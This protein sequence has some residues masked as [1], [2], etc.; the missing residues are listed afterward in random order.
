MTKGSKLNIKSTR[1]AEAL[2]RSGIKAK[3]QKATPSSAK[4]AKSKSATL[5][6]EAAELGASEEL[7]TPEVQPRVKARSHSAFEEAHQETLQEEPESVVAEEEVIFV[8]EA[9]VEE[10]PPPVEEIVQIVAEEAPQAAP[11]QVEE[12]APEVK[13]EVIPPPAPTPTPAPAPVAEKAPPSA[14]KPAAP[15]KD[16]PR[17]GAQPFVLMK[18]FTQRREEEAA[19]RQEMQKPTRAPSA[20]LL[21]PTGRHIRDLA[22]KEVER[23]PRPAEAAAERHPPRERAEREAPA[24]AREAGADG[25]ARNPNKVLE[26]GPVAEKGRAKNKLK[27]FEDLKPSKKA[28]KGVGPKEARPGQESDEGSWSRRRAPKVKRVINEELTVR[29]KELSVRLPITIKDLA[30]Q[31]KLK[32][33]QLIQKLFLQGVVVTL[34][35]ALEDPTTVQLLGHEFEVNINIDTSE[36]ARLRITD[37]T[38]KEEIA[39]AAEDNVTIRPPVA[40]FMGHVDHGKTSLIDAIR[41]SN[42]AHGEAGAITQHIGAFRCTTPAGDLAIL[43][44]PGHEAFSAMRARGAE[45]TDIVVLVVAGDEGIR[46]QTEEAIQHAKAAG[47]TIIVACNKCDK[48]NFDVEKVYRQLA[49]M[50]L[51]PEAWGG[52]TITVNTSAITGEGIETL[53]EMIALQSEVLELKANPSARARGTVLESAMHKGMGTVATLLVQNGTLRAGDSLVFSQHWGRVKTLTNEHNERLEE[54]GPST[55]VL[56][57]GL[58]GLPEAGEEFIVVPSEKEA[59]KIAEAR[60]IGVRERSLHVSRAI[61]LENLLQKASDKEKKILNLILRA[62]VQGSVE[63]LKVALE[64]IKSD[65]VDLNIILSGVGEISESDVQLAASSKAMILGFHT[66]VEMHAEP[67]LKQF[68]IVVRMHNIIYHAIDE[69]KDLMAGMLDKIAVEKEQGQALIQAVFKSS[70]LG[71]IAG[72]LVKEGTIHR[73]HMMR[74]IR[75]GK[76]IGKGS[77]SSL[78]RLKDD[79]REVKAGVECG[80]VLNG[81]PEFEPGDI[82]QAY[83]ISYITQEL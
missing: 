3:L 82:L 44:T 13:E 77:I 47:V 12:P 74:L 7:E 83:E 59:R 41:K 31:M 33:A 80:I 10:L 23:K 38:I 16:K 63:A 34:N 72:C 42:I 64:K 69:V 46:K 40:A 66:S 5:A 17:H 1:I 36:A 30:A 62:D 22:P 25:A 2:G 43:D 70:S 50:D 15:R 61:N 29:P 9:P 57:T 65:K 8:E 67:L 76:E 21:G 6:Q 81:M 75:N 51:L 37:K 27:E 19:R 45:V 26:R 71:K 79:V 54:A 32:A 52:Q 18:T 58:S 20:P 11:V 78:K 39:E 24:G 48:P 73:N 4:A 14:A 56:V 28:V 49:D 55:P 53:L 68:G 35:D 60:Q